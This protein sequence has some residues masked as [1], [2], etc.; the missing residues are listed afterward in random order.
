MIYNIYAVRDS[1]SG[2]GSLLLEQNDAVAMRNFY[3][4]FVDTKSVLH[5]NR[6]DFDLVRLG[7]FDNETGKI[8]VLDVRSV[9][10]EGINYGVGDQNEV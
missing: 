7:D 8:N 9:V 6:K 5:N 3:N 10:A 1:K 2:Y 4:A